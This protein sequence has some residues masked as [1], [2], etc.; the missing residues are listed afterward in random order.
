MKIL[1]L[2][3]LCLSGLFAMIV[4]GCS[5][6][7]SASVPTTAPTA[8]TAAAATNPAPTT[9]ATG[10][11]GVITTSEGVMVVEFYPDVAPKHVE[12][13]K[14]LAKKGFY[15]GTAF[16]RVIPGFMI[17]GGDPNTKN[18]NAKDTWGQ[19]GPGYTINA[20]FNPKH[21]ARGILSMARTPDPNSAGSQFFICHADAGNL[22]GQYTV[23]GNLIKGL[24]VLDKIATTPTE[25]SDRP[26]KRINIESIKIVPADSV[27]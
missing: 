4:A 3:L 23:F 14:T 8:P 11:V 2:N 5:N 15:D 24:D 16:H 27:K 7:K 19:G 9:S 20:E 22:D 17:Q 26:V 1:K 18:E 25:G 12:N 21:H 13:F 6:D 10:E